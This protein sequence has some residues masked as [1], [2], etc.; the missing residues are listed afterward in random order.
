MATTDA[1][2]L[3]AVLTVVILIPA[4]IVGFRIGS[5]RSA[6]LRLWTIAIGM[7]VAAAFWAFTF[8]SAWWGALLILAAGGAAWTGIWRHGK[9]STA[10]PTGDHSN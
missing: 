2:I 1:L 7:I 3:T 6:S 9:Q 4:V 5:G 8:T 10:E